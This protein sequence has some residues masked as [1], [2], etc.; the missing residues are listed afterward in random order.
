[1]DSYQHYKTINYNNGDFYFFRV[2][3]EKEQVEWICLRKNQ[4]PFIFYHCPVQLVIRL[5][6]Q[7]MLEEI[8]SESYHNQ[9]YKILSKKYEVKSLN[10]DGLRRNKKN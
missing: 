8:T 7:F 5:G 3:F 10:T 1:M 6:M 9:L 2:N 4:I